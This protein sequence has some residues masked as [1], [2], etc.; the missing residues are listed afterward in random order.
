MQ[1]YTTPLEELLSLL[2]AALS[3]GKQLTDRQIKL[4]NKLLV[5]IR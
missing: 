2:T 1:D 3:T 5:Y 4:G